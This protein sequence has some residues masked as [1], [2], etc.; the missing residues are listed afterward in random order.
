VSYRL[1]DSAESH[2]SATGAAPS[3]DHCDSCWVG[4]GAADQL[5]EPARGSAFQRQ[6]AAPPLSQNWRAVDER[7]PV[8]LRPA[9]PGA[10]NDTMEHLHLLV[11]VYLRYQ[12]SPQTPSCRSKNAMR[13]PLGC[14]LDQTWAALST[15]FCTLLYSR[16]FTS[17]ARQGPAQASMNPSALAHQGMVAGHTYRTRRPANTWPRPDVGTGRSRDPMMASGSTPSSRRCPSRSPTGRRSSRGDRP[18]R[19]YTARMFILF[20]R[21]RKKDLSGMTRDG[22][23]HSASCSDLGG[24]VE[25]AV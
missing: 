1:R 11:V 22:E 2:A 5:P 13:R 25:T 9:R 10:K 14:L 23:G 3:D 20:K 21:H 17:A 12:R 7:A 18:L 15:R 4:G 16:F 8:P 19:G 24:C 6:G